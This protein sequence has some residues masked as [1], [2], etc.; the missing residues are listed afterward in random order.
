MNQRTTSRR[1]ARNVIL[2]MTAVTAAV[3]LAIAMNAVAPDLMRQ[4]GERL[5]EL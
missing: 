3:F 2:G 1:L 4:I 5:G